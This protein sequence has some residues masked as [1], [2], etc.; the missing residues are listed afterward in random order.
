MD[1]GTG[2]WVQ[3]VPTKI[4]SNTKIS[5]HVG[6][7]MIKFTVKTIKVARKNCIQGKFEYKWKTTI[8]IAYQPNEI[9]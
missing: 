6:F 9:L 3:K 1:I 8:F 5:R 2:T 7:K 4:H